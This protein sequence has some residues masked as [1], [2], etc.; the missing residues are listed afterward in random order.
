MRR[1]PTGAGGQVR[2]VGAVGRRRPGRAEQ[3]QVDLVG[4]GDR[5][6]GHQALLAVTGSEQQD[7][8]IGGDH[9]ASTAHDGLVQPRHRWFAGHCER[10]AMEPLEPRG[11]TGELVTERGERPEYPDRERDRAKREDRRHEDVLAHLREQL[12][13]LDDQQDRLDAHDEQRG[14]QDRE[15]AQRAQLRRRARQARIRDQPD[16]SEDREHGDGNERQRGRGGAGGTRQDG[17]ARE[18]REPEPQADPPEADPVPSAR[19]SSGLHECSL[20][21]GSREATPRTWMV[22]RPTS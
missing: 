1:P 4:L 13:G 11:A 12:V 15:H 18:Q 14:Q 5:R 8:P 3:G 22:V 16:H 2:A 21:V 20:S 17:A 10:C 6:V 7:G 19:S 9:V